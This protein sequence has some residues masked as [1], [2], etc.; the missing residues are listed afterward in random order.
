VKQVNIS[1]VNFVMS[2]GER[3]SRRFQAYDRNFDS[4]IRKV[5]LGRKFAINI[6][7]AAWEASI[8][9]WNFG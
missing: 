7:K 5:A 4:N 8:A 6:W 1:E 2:T 9:T 3:L